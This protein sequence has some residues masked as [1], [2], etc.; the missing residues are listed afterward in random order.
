L[1]IEQKLFPGK[2]QAERDVEG[3]FVE[4]EPGLERVV[5]RP[6]TAG[7]GGLLG[8][9]AEC[10]TAFAPGASAAGDPLFDT[11]E[12]HDKSRRS[13]VAIAFEGNRF[14]FSLVGREDVGLPKDSRG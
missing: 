13:A 3:R 7:G 4:A 1:G 6:R 10:E 11:V 14:Q 9:G 12:T 8:Q 2:P 5:A